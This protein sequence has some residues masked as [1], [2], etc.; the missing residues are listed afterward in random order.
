MTE[1]KNSKSLSDRILY[2]I[3][4]IFSAF[5]LYTAFA[6]PFISTVQRGVCVCGGIA[7]WS[8]LDMK[9]PSKEVK[10]IDRILDVFMIVVLTVLMIFF[11]VSGKTILMP[12]FKMNTPLF[13]LGILFA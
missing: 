12:Q 5:F 6:G 1:N 8:L 7:L 9:D 10:L 4:V 2:V 11:I 3:C 13:V